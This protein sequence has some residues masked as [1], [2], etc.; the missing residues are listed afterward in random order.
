MPIS[1]I[2][3]YGALFLCVTWV[4]LFI[5]TAPVQGRGAVFSISQKSPKPFLKSGPRVLVNLYRKYNA[6]APTEVRDAALANDRSVSALPEDF[7]AEYLCP[8][9]IGGQTLNLNFDTGSS[10]L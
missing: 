2:A 10:D 1:I 4:Q 9:K 8:V 6:E 3:M 7:D 5:T